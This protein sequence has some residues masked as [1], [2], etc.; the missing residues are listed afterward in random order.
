MKSLRSK[1]TSEFGVKILK[2]I[3]FLFFLIFVVNVKSQTLS[4]SGYSAGTIGTT[5]NVGTAPNNMRVVVTKNSLTQADGAPKY[6][7]S[8]P[9]TPCYIS[10]SLALY[11][12]QFNG[13]SAA[14]NANYTVTIRFN[15]SANGT[16]NY[17]TFTIKD[18]NS[19]ENGGT[20]LDVVE[21]SAIDGNNN[22][23]TPTTNNLNTTAGQITSTINS[24]VVTR[25][26]SGSILKIVGHSSI[27]E[28]YPGANVAFTSTC[29]TSTFRVNPPS[30]V[31]L[32]SI[33]IKYRPGYGTSSTGYYNWSGPP[34]RPADQ[35]IS[36]SDITLTSTASC[37]P[38]PIELISF[39]G[40]KESRFNLLKWQTV[41][42]HNNEYFTLERSTDGMEWE[43]AGLLNGAGNSMDEMN[44]QYEDHFF[45]HNKIN[46]YKLSQ[47]DFDGSIE[48]VGAVVAID[49]RIVLKNVV[50]ITN[51]LGQD[52]PPNA[53]GMLIY[54]YDD[55]SLEK[56]Y[57]EY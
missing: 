10:G 11:A 52:V 31:P 41:S 26:T 8:D 35:Y 30:G 51:L 38:L 7:S 44:Y 39:F 17:A 29:Q 16:C 54:V 6:V 20:F 1:L 32:K 5:Y 18:I 43:E 24:S 23:I 45:V 2:N 53:K 34:I 19:F 55:G 40:I 28:T 22:A 4:W 49:N 3:I 42:E 9:G 33:T 13:I 50:R 47:T 14:D 57:V 48:T 46:Y 12:G 56:V 25:A 15:P 36:I 27:S 37:T 21:I